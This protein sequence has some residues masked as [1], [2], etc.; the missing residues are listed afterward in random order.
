M[1]AAA[2]QTEDRFD[3]NCDPEKLSA[4]GAKVCAR[5]DSIPQVERVPVEGADFYVVPGFLEKRDCKEIVRV[6]DS[7]AVPSTLYR[8]T[9]R[10]DFRTSWTHHFERDDPFTLDIEDYIS[11]LLGIDNDYSEVMQGQ[12]YHVG[13]EFKHHHDFFHLGE[14]YWQEEAH[15][16]GQRTW[17][18][19]V[20]LDE[21]KEGGHTDFPLLGIAVKPKTGMLVIWNNMDE[22]GRPNMK[23]LHA[24]T[25]VL[26]GVKHVIT[27]WYRQEPWRLLTAPETITSY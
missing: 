9:E 7:R 17:T 8:G 6:I 20:C 26:K 11:K 3:P 24:G 10:K 19:M 12:R 13:Q 5:L 14:G 18:A 4:I 27:K 15:R 22:N 25:P 2:T 1:S 21:P 23:T 16:G